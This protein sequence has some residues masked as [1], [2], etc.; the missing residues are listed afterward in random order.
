MTPEQATDGLEVTGPYGTGILVRQANGWDLV[1]GERV[2]QSI[3]LAAHV[4]LESRPPIVE[5]RT[6]DGLRAGSRE[7]GKT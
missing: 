7:R 6:G 4:A 3:D 2:Y 5:I 1:V